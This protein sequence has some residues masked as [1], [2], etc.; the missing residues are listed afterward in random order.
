M[1]NTITSLIN[2]LRN[3][4]LPLII[5]GVLMTISLAFMY[6]FSVGT[7]IIL[8]GGTHLFAFVT[9]FII[10]TS[11]MYLLAIPLTQM[12][13]D[14]TTE[15]CTKIKPTIMYA[16]V[17]LV[18]TYIA[19]NKEHFISLAIIYLFTMIGCLTGHYLNSPNRIK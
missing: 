10:I 13:E 2:W 14:N 4:V 15:I 17:M 19:I 7:I 1:G 16:I 3:E 18:I 8:L 6:Y 12:W 5:V 9:W 11:I